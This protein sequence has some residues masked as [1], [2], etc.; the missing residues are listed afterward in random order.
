MKSRTVHGCNILSVTRQVSIERMREPSEIA[1]GISYRTGS[2][3]YDS[4]ER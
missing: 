2:A 4:I 3:S 1:S